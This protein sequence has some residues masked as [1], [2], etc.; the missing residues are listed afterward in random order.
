MLVNF[1][2]R[3]P[4]IA[5][6]VCAFAVSGQVAHASQKDRTDPSAIDAAVA[7]FTGAQIGEIGGA[8]VPADHRLQLAACKAPLKTAWHGTN[9]S[10]VRVECEGPESWR[11]FIATRPLPQ[12]AQATKIVKRGDPITV[13][14]KGHGFSVQQTGEALEAGTIGDWISIRTAR[15]ADPIRARIERPG[16]A[17]IPAG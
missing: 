10:T 16:I 17:M 9:R 5:G 11:I 15:Q 8:R 13:V 14:I 4:F 2:C 7:Q 6:L 1:V 12:P 3:W